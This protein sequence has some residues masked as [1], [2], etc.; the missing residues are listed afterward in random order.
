MRQWNIEVWIFLEPTLCGQRVDRTLAH[1]EITARLVPRHVVL[2]IGQEEG[3]VNGGLCFGVGMAAHDPDRAA[4]GCDAVGRVFA[5]LGEGRDPRQETA[6]TF[7]E[8]QHVADPG[9]GAEM[10]RGCAGDEQ[11]PFGG[12]GFGAAAVDEIAL[13]RKVFPPCQDVEHFRPVEQD[14][15]GAAS[16][17]VLVVDE[18]RVL[19]REPLFR[20]PARDRPVDTTLQR[21]DPG[22]HNRVTG[23][24]DFCKGLR[25]IVRVQ[26]GGFEHQRVEIHHRVGG[27]PGQAPD[28]FIQVVVIAHRCDDVRDRRQLFLAGVVADL[29]EELRIERDLPQRIFELDHVRPGALGGGAQRTLEHIGVAIRRGFDLYRNIRVGFHKI[30]RNLIDR[31]ETNI[32]FVGEDVDKGNLDRVALGV[33][34]SGRGEWQNAQNHNDRHHYE[35]EFFLQG[36]SSLHDGRVSAPLIAKTT[37]QL[38]RR[39]FKSRFKKCKYLFNLFYRQS[40]RMSNRTAQQMQCCR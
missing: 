7:R 17:A 30:S 20:Q 35:S 14:F 38:C 8:G 2:G 27:V 25:R 10:D 40:R 39:K 18:Q 11:Q 4:A 26:S 13:V 28:F 33:Q 29:D 32:A 19:H 3:E 31:G 12:V 16:G 21:F 9:A 5:G 15:G 36:V 34:I 37:Y 6:Q 22:A 1:R 24:G 23:G